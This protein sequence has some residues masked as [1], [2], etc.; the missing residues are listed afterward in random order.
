M[1]ELNWTYDFFDVNQKDWTQGQK[2]S[3][4]PLPEKNQLYYFMISITMDAIVINSLWEWNIRKW[5]QQHLRTLYKRRCMF[6]YK[7]HLLKWMWSGLC[8]SFMQD[9][10][11]T[12]SK[13]TSDFIIIITEVNDLSTCVRMY[14]VKMR[15]VRIVNVLFVC[16]SL[17]MF[18]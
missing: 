8:G 17:K 9:A 11:V 16:V 15:S 7:R 6:S 10:W 12:Y 13:H 3:Y 18:L 5:L 2:L 1:N 14:G 4:S